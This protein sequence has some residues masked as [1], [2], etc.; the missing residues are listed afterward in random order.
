MPKNIKRDCY[1]MASENGCAEITMYGEIV[2]S[3]PTN[4]WTGE[5]ENGNFII[6]D[7]FLEDLK[8]VSDCQKI[9][10]RMNSVGGSC[11]VSL[12]IHNRLR[13]L[14]EQGKEISCIVDGV[15]M[16]G[17]SVIMCACDN[18]K[19]YASSLIMIH[20]C[21]SFVFGGYNADELENLAKSNRAYDDAIIAAYVRK[22]GLDAAEISKMMSNETYMTGKEAVEKGFADVLCES[23]SPVKIAASADKK[24]LFAN[25][26][27][28]KLSRNIPL[29]ETIK[30][31]TETPKGDDSVK[32]K[33]IP[34]QENSATITPEAAAKQA[35][36]SERKRIEEIDAIASMY[37]AETVRNAKYNKPC[38]AQ[39]MAYNAALNES[40]KGAE[41]I[42]NLREDAENSHVQD[43]HA[44]VSPE[45]ITIPKS[46]EDLMNNAREKVH[47][48]NLKGDKK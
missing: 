43:V 10:I 46:E 26:I 1:C 33:N 25:G 44:A 15:A 2:E 35:I 17:G 23:E 34:E 37:D 22:T 14:A 20:K 5:S 39:E 4:Y 36:E 30:T 19:V 18:V 8:S 7:E 9:N 31:I 48:F 32:N 12:L 47:L 29:P 27:P 38:T 40:K 3:Q 28:M 13:E 16:S 41:F 24:I 45:I 6:Q 21:W 11:G 42:K